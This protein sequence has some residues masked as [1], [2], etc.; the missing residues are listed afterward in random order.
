MD[1]NEPN[2][3]DVGDRKDG[4]RTWCR[5]YEFRGIKYNIAMLHRSPSRW[6]VV[7][8]HAATRSIVKLIGRS[9][10]RGDFLYHVCDQHESWK[11]MFYDAVDRAKKD[12]DWFL[13]DALNDLAARMKRDRTMFSDIIDARRIVGGDAYSRRNKQ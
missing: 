2:Y 8:P 3:S 12:I 7:E 9:G 6:F 11:S 5:T 4:F 1:T 13:D 10:L